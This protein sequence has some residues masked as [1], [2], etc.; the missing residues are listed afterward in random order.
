MEIDS[1]L[2]V[3]HLGHQSFT[4]F[5]G[6]GFDI[7][8]ERRIVEPLGIQLLPQILQLLVDLKSPGK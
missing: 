8:E 1:D 5:G 2:L 3:D 6:V 4:K 7:S